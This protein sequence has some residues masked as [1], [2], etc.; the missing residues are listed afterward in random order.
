MIWMMLDE[1]SAILHRISLAKALDVILH[2]PGGSPD[3]IYLG[4]IVDLHWV[5]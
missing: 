5:I 4:K 1:E 3:D 2:H